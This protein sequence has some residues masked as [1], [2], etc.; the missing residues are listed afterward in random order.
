[1][2][3][4]AQLLPSGFYDLLPHDAAMEYDSVVRLLGVFSSFGYE[5]V[6][7]PLMEF[8]ATLLAGRGAELSKQTFRV[9][10]PASGNM[11]GI[12]SDM[13]LQV[14]R[15]A[16]SR[17]ASSGRPLRL[18]YAGQILQAV[19]DALR[20]ERQLTQA[21]I[22]LIGSDSLQADIEVIIIAVQAL[23]A[24][25]VHDISIDINLPG[26]IGELCPEARDNQKL[27][28]EIKDAVL[29]KDAKMI[30]RLP[31]AANSILASL[32]G[33]AGLIEKALD[34]MDGLKISQAG[35]IRELAK[36][37]S[38]NCPQVTLTVD[39]IEYRGF[40]Y[41]NGISFS[42]FA[43]GVRHELGRGGRYIVEG[44][45]ATGFTIYVTNLLSRLPVPEK[46]KRVCV[47]KDVSV[48]RIRDLHAQG[49]E[50]VYALTDNLMEAANKSGCR[51]QIASDDAKVLDI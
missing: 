2:N 47:A 44:E 13:T 42:I 34:V 25:G 3:K 31:V 15:I 21:G 30:A 49:W 39:P 41:H 16:A 29:R 45:P 37:V 26:L 23:S 7:P 14:A 10:D 6:S 9:L 36:R 40:D 5:Q 46:K 12:R 51:F 33:A 22:E 32:A 11:M 17:L 35:A 28:A 8:E 4:K 24:L 27:R 18:C 50:T 20:N 19:P 38:A 48:A 1:M 43:K